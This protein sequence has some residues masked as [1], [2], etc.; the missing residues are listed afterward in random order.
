MRISAKAELQ[1]V[2]DKFQNQ[3][4]KYLEEN[5]DAE[6]NSPLKERLEK[7][8]NYFNEKLEINIV[9]PLTA[10]DLD[11]DNKTVKKQ[12][13]RTI[14]NLLIETET[15]LA[16]FEVC[17]SGFNVKALLNEQAKASLDTKSAKAKAKKAKPIQDLENIPHPELYKTLRAWRYEKSSESGI[18]AYMIFSQKALIE[19]VNYLPVDLKSLQLINGLGAKKIEHYGADILQII[20]LYCDSN[21]IERGLIPL[22]E[23]PKKEKKPREDTKKVSF[24]M[25]QSGK[26]MEEIAKERALSKNTIESHLAHFVKLGELEVT[27]FLEEAKLKKITAYFEKMENKSFGEAKA[28]FGDE[29]S[30]GELRMGLSYLESLQKE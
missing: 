19:L 22:K 9:I 26:T 20:Q 7:A 6:N 23:N 2:A 15:K 24:E 4:R 13:K 28:H 10:A 16:G 21:D 30:Y 11:I 17:K 14:E 27:T 3:L 18:P 29:V 8:S 12:L 5:A 1:E 25:F